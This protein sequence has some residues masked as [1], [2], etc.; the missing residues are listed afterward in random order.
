MKA[1]LR[2]FLFVLATLS[3]S[4]IAQE[5]RSTDTQHCPA[6]TMSCAITDE[7]FALWKSDNSTAIIDSRQKKNFD[8]VHIPGSLNAPLFSIKTK[9]H[10]KNRKLLL[11]GESYEIAALENICLELKRT[12]FE[13]VRFLRGG[14]R[15]WLLSGSTLAGN[16]NLVTAAPKIPAYA[17]M[18]ELGKSRWRLLALSC[19]KK[20][21]E[22]QDWPGVEYVDRQPDGIQAIAEAIARS[23]SAES[24]A[25]IAC[26][27]EPDRLYDELTVKLST[28]QSK[29]LYYVD[30]GKN[31]L[32][33]FKAQYHAI[34][35]GGKLQGKSAGQCQ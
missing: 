28:A 20:E 5:V 32:D 31:A 17:L 8:L 2:N 14:I 10:L 11:L 24:I 33:R 12:G 22:Q 30:G 9:T 7:E 16:S 35:T 25:L 26:G 4:V 34:L 13:H 23:S 19:A 29:N 21:L 18:Q 1:C 3:H 27:S 6:P 15:S